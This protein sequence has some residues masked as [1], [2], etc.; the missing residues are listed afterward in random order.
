MDKWEYRILKIEPKWLNNSYN[1]DEVELLTTINL[2]GSDGWEV[3]STE[4]SVAAA[5]QGIDYLYVFLKRKRN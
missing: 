1:I 3:I 2:L 4:A 5:S